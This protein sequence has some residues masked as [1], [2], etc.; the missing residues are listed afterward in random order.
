M[1]ASF[2]IMHVIYFH[3]LINPTNNKIQLLFVF[4][5]QVK[6]LIVF[7]LSI[8][9]DNYFLTITHNYSQLLTITHI[10]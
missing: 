6:L 9:N 2:F 7:I 5:G 1:S 3:K 4:F 10:K 8:F